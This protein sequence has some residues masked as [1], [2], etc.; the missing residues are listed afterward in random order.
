MRAQASKATTDEN[1]HYVEGESAR[2]GLD[3]ACADIVSCSQALH[4]LEPEPTFKEVC[5]ILRPGGVFAAYDYVW[6]PL[7]NAEC[8]AA[9]DELA[10]RV[11]QEEAMRDRSA[12][13]RHWDKSGHLDRLRASGLFAWVKTTHLHHV[14]P[15]DATRLVNLI[16]SQSAVA[17]LLGAGVGEEALGLAEYE[18]RVRASL[19]DVPTSFFWCYQ[20]W[21][22][23]A[24]RSPFRE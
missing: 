1:V 19:R 2:T 14:E 23:S 6:P 22:A 15:G 7:V 18:R 17:L 16:R 13:A 9:F 8:D 12:G 3:A 21:L 10:A 5:R 24:P 11:E 4:W 20:V